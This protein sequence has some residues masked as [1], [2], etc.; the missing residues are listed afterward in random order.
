MRSPT[1]VRVNFAQLDWVGKVFNKA[2]S[3]SFSTLNFNTITQVAANYKTGC[4]HLALPNCL[5]TLPIQTSF[6]CIPSKKSVELQPI[7]V[8]L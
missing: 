8:G 4:I 7:F 1:R 6:G 3:Y 2:K 5:I